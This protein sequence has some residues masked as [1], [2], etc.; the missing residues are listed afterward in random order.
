M[1][2]VNDVDLDETSAESSELNGSASHVDARRVS[3]D[4]VCGIAGGEDEFR[5]RRWRDRGGARG[6]AAGGESQHE[7]GQN[8][9]RHLHEIYRQTAEEREMQI[10]R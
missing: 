10:P 6:A 9:V 7:E 1:V 5:G 4:P 2:V 3:P 8:P